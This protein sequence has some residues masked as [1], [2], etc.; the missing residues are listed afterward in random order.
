MEGGWDGGG[1]AEGSR[2]KQKDAQSSGDG[3]ALW[4]WT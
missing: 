1:I 3:M 2:G 4:K